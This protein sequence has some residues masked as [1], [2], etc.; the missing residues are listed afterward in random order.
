MTI[1]AQV[2]TVLDHTQDI[3]GTE[4]HRLTSLHAPPEF[5]KQATHER[6]HGNS[7]VLPAH[8]YAD[9]TTRTWPLHAAPAVWMSSLFFFDKKANLDPRKAELIEQRI[10]AA[11]RFHNILPEVE[12]LK[13]KV[14]ESLLHDLSRV[15]DDDFALVW[16]AE[17]HK[18]RHYPLR[19]QDEVKMASMWFERYRDEFAWADRR[20]IAE[21]IYEKAA[22]YGVLLDNQEMLQKTAGLGHAP[23]E[24]VLAMLSTRAS[25]VGRTHPEHKDELLKLAGIIQQHGL[26][27]QDHGMR[28]KLAELID[29][30]DRQTQ[31]NRLYDAGGLERPE[32][33]LFKVTAKTAYDFVNSHIQ[34]PSGTIYEKTAF[35]ELPLSHVQDWMGQEFAEA[36][37]AG[38]MFVDPEKIAEIAPTLPRGDAEIF[39]RMAQTGGVNAFAITKAAADEGLTTQEL[40]ALAADYGNTRGLVGDAS[41]L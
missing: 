20:R 24:D 15:P 19:N 10:L 12:Q 23:V 41:V 7:E 39:D 30:F 17:G 38:G 14:A 6:L 13:T 22:Q 33:V 9:Q 21:K 2:A 4:T 1:P 35:Q 27:H 29:Q 28:F 40:V 37:S 11:A 31:L 18:E 5:V 36:V 25:M 26:T 3:S 16:E 32:E 8:V 34:M